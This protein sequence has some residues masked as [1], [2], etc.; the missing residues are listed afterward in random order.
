MGA[1]KLAENTP[2]APLNFWP[3]LSAQAQKFGIYKK[4]L[5]LAVRS[6]CLVGSYNLRR[7]QKFCEI[8]TLDLFYVVRVKSTR[9]L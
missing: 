2:N 9:E 7:P 5:S 6:L 3:N 8:S 4:D 1:D